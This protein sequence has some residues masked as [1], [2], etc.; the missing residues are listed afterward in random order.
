MR[1]GLDAE[2][3]PLFA[4]VRRG[5]SLLSEEEEVFR[6]GANTVPLP[7]TFSEGARLTQAVAT[8]RRVIQIGNLERAKCFL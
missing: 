4:K 7:M 5:R 6:P 3:L 1:R 8:E 2:L